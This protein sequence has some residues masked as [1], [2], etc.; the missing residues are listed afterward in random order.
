MGRGVI[1]LGQ[2]LVDGARLPERQARVWVFDGRH[3]AI[4]V[5]VDEGRLLD[6]VEAEGL[7]LIVEAQLLED[8]DCLW[9]L[10]DTF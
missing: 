2:V 1:L 4:W 3:P 7:D 6:I 5:D 9:C 10:S 8:E